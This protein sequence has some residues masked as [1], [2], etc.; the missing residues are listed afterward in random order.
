VENIVSLTMNLSKSKRMTWIFIVSAATAIL[1]LVSGYLQYK[2]K[3][4]SAQKSLKKEEELKEVYKQL[5]E[6]SDSIIS[7][8]QVNRNST[9]DLNQK[10]ESA[11]TELR[12]ANRKIFDFQKENIQELK[13][14][15]LPSIILRT[16]GSPTSLQILLSNHC[17]YPI[18]FLSVEVGGDFDPSFTRFIPPI[19]D[20]DIS[21]IQERT[22]KVVLQ[23]NTT[24]TAYSK[25]L[26]MLIN[27]D[28]VKFYF[29]VGW[30]SDSY[31]G[32]AT[33]V[34]RN[35]NYFEIKDE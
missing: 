5:S 6:K 10:L 27:K 9:N 11:N 1:A 20:I 19:D 12:E 23:S 24:Y 26:S 22:E 18:H 4:E 15:D 2:E 13:G 32:A 25:D 28:T 16:T 17:K 34:K 35:H 7:L 8:Q 29:Q 30:R 31:M 33:L 21:G 3:I 14:G